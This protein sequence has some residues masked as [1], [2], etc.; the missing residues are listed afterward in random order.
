MKKTYESNIFVNFV[1][2]DVTEEQFRSK[3]EKAGKILS[4]KLLDLVQT[5][6]ATGE[7]YVNFKKGYV[8]YE[9][10]KQAQK[11]IQEFDNTNPFG[12][13]NKPLKVDFWQSKYDIEKQQE[14]KSNNQVKSMI[15]FIQ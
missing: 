9:D 10:V 6:K 15:N 2:K 11:C 8:C 13:R 5:N 1:P 14:E 4:F 3:F 12:Y 7:S